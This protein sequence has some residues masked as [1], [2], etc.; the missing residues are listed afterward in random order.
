MATYGVENLSDR[1]L[2][3]EEISLLKRGLK[4]YPTPPC[5][6]LGQ[7]REDLNTLQRRMSLFAFYEENPLDIIRTP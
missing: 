4:F 7:A 6:N 1:P 2:T 3:E 5:T